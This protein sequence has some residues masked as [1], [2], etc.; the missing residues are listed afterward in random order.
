MCCRGSKVWFSSTRQRWNDVSASLTI[1]D[2]CSSKG[3][4]SASKAMNLAAFG[5]RTER[6]E[7]LVPGQADEQRPH[8]RL[9]D[10][11][12]LVERFRRD[13]LEQE[14]VVANDVDFFLGR[15]R[16][17]IIEAI[18]LSFGRVCELP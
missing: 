17:P 13:V 11:G 18:A 5:V 1:A 15:R 9:Q 16:G 12:R 3:S 8:Q 6:L 14:I 2:C 10:I 7:I 4:Y